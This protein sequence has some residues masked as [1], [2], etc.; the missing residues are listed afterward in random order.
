MLPGLFGLGVTQLN[1]V[2]DSQ[3]GIY[4]TLTGLGQVIY[5]DSVAKPLG[6]QFRRARCFARG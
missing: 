3:G 1:L 6:V 2:V 4:Y 5:I